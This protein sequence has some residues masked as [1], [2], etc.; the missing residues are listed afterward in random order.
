MLCI[1]KE[2]PLQLRSA[3]LQVT[4]SDYDSPWQL[5]SLLSLSLSMRNQYQQQQYLLIVD[6]KRKT[7]ADFESN[8]TKVS[9]IDTKLSPKL[10]LSSS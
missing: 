1:H 4:H 7:R 3:F 2:I 5:A 9:S 10:N 6:L 8:V